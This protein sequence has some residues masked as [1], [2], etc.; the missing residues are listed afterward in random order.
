MIWLLKCFSLPSPFLQI[1]AQHLQLIRSVGTRLGL[2]LGRGNGGDS[3]VL[4]VPKLLGSQ[5][6]VGAAWL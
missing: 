1:I 4:W 3:W 2:S 6:G 5:E